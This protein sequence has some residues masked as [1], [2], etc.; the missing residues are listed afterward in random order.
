VKEREEE[1]HRPAHGQ[2]SVRVVDAVGHDVEASHLEDDGAGAANPLVFRR[3]SHLE[4]EEEGGEEE[5][6]NRP[7]VAVEGGIAQVSEEGDVAL[8]DVAVPE[9][10]HDQRGV[11]HHEKGQEQED[12]VL[13][14]EVGIDGGHDLLWSWLQLGETASVTPLLL[15]LLKRWRW[16]DKHSRDLCSIGI[17]PFLFPRGRSKRRRR[18][19]R[20]RGV[21][22]LLATNEGRGKRGYVVE[23]GPPNRGINAC[24]EV[25][26][27]GEDEGEVV[28]AKI[29]KDEEGQLEGEEEA[30][31]GPAG[32]E[33]ALGEA[34]GEGGKEAKGEGEEE[35]E[36][37]EEKVDEEGDAKGEEEEDGEEEDGVVIAEEDRVHQEV[38]VEEDRRPGGAAEAGEVAGEPLEVGL[39]GRDEGEEDEKLA[40]GGDLPGERDGGG[41]KLAPRLPLVKL[42]PE[43]EAEDGEGEGDPNGE[44]PPGDLA[45]GAKPVEP[46]VDLVLA[47]RVKPEL[48]VNSPV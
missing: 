31:T 23:D 22:A 46:H 34:G 3:R 38:G 47:G 7:E 37:L 25:V 11:Y 10:G 29:G 24:H 12:H 48:E 6:R 21:V 8:D 35:D 41:G 36:G 26:D 9:P 30:E 1:T 5:R 39:D 15:L 33:K 20:R 28:G 40:H 2:N 44:V 17:S 32:D 45:S 27:K 13:L 4:G 18:R 43:A 14:L 19:R 42:E 16:N